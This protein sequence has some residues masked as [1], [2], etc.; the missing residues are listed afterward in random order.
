MD[1]DLSF[2]FHINQATNTLFIIFAH[3]YYIKAMYTSAIPKLQLIQNAAVK[4]LMKLRRKEHI[5]GFYYIYIGC[6]FS[7]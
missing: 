6:Q 7:K 1:Y 5:N 2:T 4:V 3:H